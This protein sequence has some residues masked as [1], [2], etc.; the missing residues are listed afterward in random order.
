MYYHK[1]TSLGRWLA[2]IL[3]LSLIAVSGVSAG[4]RESELAYLDLNDDEVGLMD[5]FAFLEEEDI[6]YTAAKHEQDIGES[7]SAI[8]VITR[9]QI[10][11]TYCTDVVCLL[12]GVPEM[13]VMRI[14]PMYAAVGA[15]ALTDEAGEKV[16]LLIDGLEI[17]NEIFGTVIWQALPVHLEDIERI[18][19]IRG[20]GSALYGAN[21]HSAVVSIFTRKKVGDAAETF[22]GGELLARRIFLFAR[23]AI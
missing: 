4:D 15:R 3:T 23:G 2:A 12:R 8:T 22:L 10:E 11:N 20:P 13:M 17:N 14:R 6:V 16:L 21:A 19:V 1:G 9:E 18:E 7:P 5:E